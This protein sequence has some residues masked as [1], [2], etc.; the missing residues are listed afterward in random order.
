MTTMTQSDPESLLNDDLDYICG[1]LDE[2]FA[3]PWPASSCSSPAAPGSS[4]TT[5]SRR[6]CT[7]TGQRGRREPIRL[8]VYDNFIARR[9]GVADRRSS[10]TPT[11]RSSTHD[12]IDAA[13][14]RTCGDFEWIVHAAG[15]A[16][17]TYYRQHPIETM[18]AN[19]N[20]LRN[21]LDYCVAQQRAG[22]SRSK[23]FL[24]FSQQRDLRRPRRPTDPDARRLPRPRLLHRPARLLRRVQALRR[25]AV[26]GLRPAARHA[27]QDGAAVQQLRAGAEDHRRARASPTSPATCS[28]GRDIVMLSD[29]KPTRTFCYVADAVTGYYKVLVKG[30]PAS[31]TT[32]ASRRPRSRCASSP[33]RSSRPRAS[34]SATRGKVVRQPSPE[35]DYLVD[36]PNRRC[37]S[38]RE[39]ARRSWATTRRSLVDEGLRR[40]LIWYHHN[41]EA[42]RGDEDLHHRHRLRRP[43]HGRL[44]RRERARLRRAS[45]S[46]RPRSTRSTAGEAP[47]HEDGPRR[48]AGARTSARRLRATTRPAD[49]AVLRRDITLHRRRHAVRRQRIDLTLRPRGRPRQIGAA[50]RDK[51]G[52]HVVVVKSTVVPGTTDDVVLPHPRAGLRQ[53]SR[54]RLRRRHEPGVPHRGRRGRR[55]HEAR[56][57]RARRH[58]RAHARRAARGL[59]AVRGD[60]RSCARTTRPP[61]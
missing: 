16:S 31:R 24:F 37:P 15:I 19:I 53:A 8:T 58:R 40:S 56:P 50:L 46:T 26:R 49:A 33:R 51:T 22:R 12:M 28:P 36:N 52:Y 42:E 48:A 2:E 30:A 60:A 43:R 3:T 38:H 27:G 23:G 45:T 5:S 20:G 10:G 13:A 7:T 17:P 4:A 39:G 11:S 21:L 54:R 34:C 47:I 41:R 59:R 1:N 35:A 44:L 6:C 57:H 25:D 29:G 9:A 55:L 18:D 14:R 32:S 61:R